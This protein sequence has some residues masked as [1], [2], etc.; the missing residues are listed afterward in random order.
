MKKVSIFI[1]A[2]LG[3]I[4]LGAFT[5]QNNDEPQVGLNIGNKAPALSFEDPEGK[6]ISLEDLKGKYVLID[7]WASW[8]GPCRRE[9]PNVVQAYN[10]YSKA[11]M[12]DAKGFA[13]YSVSLDKNKRAWQKA[14]EQDKLVWDEHV[15]DLKGWASKPAQIYGVRSI[16]T[17]VLIDPNGIILAK[18]LRGPRLH[19]ELDKYV[20]KFKKQK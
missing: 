5:V 18:N 11:K 1:T 8:C 4:L 19:M 10:K 12:K 15:S 7:F 9:N 2:M 6:V 13:I 3:I 16:P 17:N 14:I 20:V